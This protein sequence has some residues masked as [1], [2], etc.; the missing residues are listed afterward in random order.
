MSA[1]PVTG[2]AHGEQQGKTQG[3]ELGQSKGLELGRELGHYRGRTDALIALCAVY[4]DRCTERCADALAAQRLLPAPCLR[5]AAAGDDA[6]LRK[7]TA[8]NQC[9]T[10]DP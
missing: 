10:S 6:R 2:V 1:S 7:R 9:P 8:I 4:P 3:L 5:V